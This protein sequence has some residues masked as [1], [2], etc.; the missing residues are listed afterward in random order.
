[1]TRKEIMKKII[2]QGYFNTTLLKFEAKTHSWKYR[3]HYFS[4]RLF[5]Y[6]RYECNRWKNNKTDTIIASKFYV[7]NRNDWKE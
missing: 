3:E 4:S 6:G 2:Y 5:D 1:M 7:S